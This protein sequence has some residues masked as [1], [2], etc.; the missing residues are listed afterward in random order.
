M[1]FLASQH[2]RCCLCYGELILNSTC[3]DWITSSFL[4]PHAPKIY[5][6]LF[7]CS[8]QIHQVLAAKYDFQLYSLRPWHSSQLCIPEIGSS[9]NL[10]GNVFF[11][12]YTFLKA[13][14][15]CPLLYYPSSSP[16]K[17]KVL[18]SVLFPLQIAHLVVPS[19]AFNYKLLVLIILKSAFPAHISFLISCCSFPFGYPTKTR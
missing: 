9:L 6:P 2:Y 3:F 1:P 7:I 14:S 8:S 18:I 17:A 4:L 16:L 11:W 19:P 10:H 12:I 13:I 15:L 5:I